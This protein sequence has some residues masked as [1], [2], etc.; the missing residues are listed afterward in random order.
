MCV[1]VMAQDWIL[2]MCVC[3]IY[4]CILMTFLID[5]GPIVVSVENSVNGETS[6]LKCL[7]STSKVSLSYS[8]THTLI[9]SFFYS[10]GHPF[11]SFAI[12]SYTLTSSLPPPHPFQ[13]SDRHLLSSSVKPK[14]ALR[15]LSR[16]Y[17]WME[18]A[19]LTRQKG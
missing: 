3:V 16:V 8:Q 17:P 7:V 1:C 2:W 15:V 19:K 12:H 13:L 4:F 10:P 14:D 18:R 6:Y 11:K 9:L 5:I